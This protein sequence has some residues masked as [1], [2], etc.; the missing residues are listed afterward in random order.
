MT[1]EYASKLDLKVR[2]INIGVQK[3][4]GS[5]LETFKIVLV[6]F[7]VKDILGKAR[8][9]QKTFLLA[10]LSIKVVLEIPFLILSNANIK[11]AYKKLT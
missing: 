8:F 10:D 3:I 6:S 9:F 2:F 11:F 5:T 4:D 7:Q 1:L